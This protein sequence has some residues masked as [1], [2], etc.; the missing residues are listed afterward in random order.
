MC[1]VETNRANFESGQ[2]MPFSIKI[3]EDR[4]L[5][6]DEVIGNFKK[7]KYKIRD[8]YEGDKGNSYGFI[9]KGYSEIKKSNYRVKLAA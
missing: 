1:M 7:E 3:C 9:I 2:G 8:K 5:L 6:K 4:C